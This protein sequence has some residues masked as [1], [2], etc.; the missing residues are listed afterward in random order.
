MQRLL[1]H[2]LLQYV[3]RPN[4]IDSIEARYQVLDLLGRHDDDFCSNLSTTIRGFTERLIEFLQESP[5]SSQSPLWYPLSR[6]TGNRRHSL[7]NWIESYITMLPL[8][9]TYVVRR[10]WNPTPVKMSRGQPTLMKYCVRCV[11]MRVRWGA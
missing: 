6:L 11:C 2:H 8:C 4:R 7:V 5:V 3:S 1:A 10:R 9:Y